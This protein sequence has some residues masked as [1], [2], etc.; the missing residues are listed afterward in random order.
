MSNMRIGHRNKSQVMPNQKSNP[1]I[2]NYGSLELT[3]QQSGIPDG[4]MTKGHS[5]F[6]IES[7]DTEEVLGS[8]WVNIKV[9]LG[10]CEGR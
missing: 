5:F 9:L 3:R 8:V 7:Q 10:D 4:L 6:A 2:G 1:E